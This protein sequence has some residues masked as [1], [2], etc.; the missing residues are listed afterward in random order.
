MTTT[1]IRVGICDDHHDYAQLLGSLVTDAPDMSLAWVCDNGTEALLPE[2]CSVIDV[3]VLDVRMPDP[4]GL[5]V[6]RELW[7]RPDAPRILF[8]T[9]HDHGRQAARLALE[10]G[11]GG[12]ILKESAPTAIIQAIR[13]VHDGAQV[14]SPQATAHLFTPA[15]ERPAKDPDLTDRE[16]K[17]LHLVT[18]GDSNAAIAQHMGL[19]EST[20]KGII[21]DIFRKFDVRSRAQLIAK[22][23][24]WNIRADQ[25]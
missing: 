17:I 20:V 9:A 23:H 22:V 13:I 19:A 14:F 6:A 16:R 18:T 3:L 2:R 7:T 24:A 5:T 12:T 4:D 1:P 25:G 15:G 11:T 21:G 10:K 8:L